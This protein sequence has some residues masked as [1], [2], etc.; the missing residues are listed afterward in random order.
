MTSRFFLFYFETTRQCNLSCPYCMT[1]SG[2]EP[3][4]NELTTDEAKHCVIDEVK[5]YS[6]RA[7]IAFSGG[8]FL[9]REDAHELIAYNAEKGLWT[10][11][12]TNGTLL[13]TRRIQEI[14]EAAQGRLV[15]VF[16]LDSVKEN[17]GT[18]REGADPDRLKALCRE[19]DVAH[20]FVVTITKQNLDQLEKVIKYVSADS[21]PVLRSPVVP[22]GRGAG[23]RD[24]MFDTEDMESVIHPLL[25][26]SWLSYIS[27]TPFFAASRFFKKNWLKTKIA[28]KQ[29]G[30]Q[31]GRG[32]VG[33]SPEGDVAPCVHLLETDAVC[34]NV[35]ESRLSDIL[36]HHPIL[37]ELRTRRNLQG[38]CG[39][40]I[41]R[42]TCG[43]CRALAYYRNGHYLAEDPVCFFEPE[44]GRKR[45]EYEQLQNE[46][47]GKF[48]DFIR[49]TS[50]W[51]DIF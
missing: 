22:R 2:P 41:Y 18:S 23:F 33:I 29:L 21:T 24:L 51:K 42:D 45:S 37:E 14:K 36:E 16:S 31:A 27:F 11:V 30:C 38:K 9:M 43:G 47:V 8:E 19:A 25:R 3:G 5:K 26:N 13:D 39:R 34:G 1:S 17:S 10:F 4:P 20:F 6:S 50:P 35:R 28:I 32:Y 44:D 12:N 40:C 7:A 46:N 48:A 49:T 15:F